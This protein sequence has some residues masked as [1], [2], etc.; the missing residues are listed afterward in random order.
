MEINKEKLIWKIKKRFKM[1][2]NYYE[3][4]TAKLSKKK[5]SGG[6]HF[7]G[8]GSKPLNPHLIRPLPPQ[9]NLKL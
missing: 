5:S 1:K 7:T 2:I 6:E 4:E 8:R 9:K 3:K